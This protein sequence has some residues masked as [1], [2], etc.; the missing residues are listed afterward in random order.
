MGLPDSGAGAGNPL[1]S[2][3]PPEAPPKK[4]VSNGLRTL[5]IIGLIMVVYGAVMLILLFTPAKQWAL[6]HS[7]AALVSVTDRRANNAV[8]GPVDEPIAYVG[9]AVLIFAGLWI[10]LLVPW[11]LNRNHAKMVAKTQESM[12]RQ[13]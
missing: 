6:E 10:G 7:I 8:Q 13:E 4:R 2:Y 11:V 12:D 1:E 5:R 3:P 9:S